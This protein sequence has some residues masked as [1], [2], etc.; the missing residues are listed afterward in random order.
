VE[1]KGEIP[2][3]IKIE[4][5]RIED[6]SL[7]FEDW[8]VKGVPA[9]IRL[10]GI[11]LNIR[12]LRFPVVSGHSPIELKGK[13]KGE[14]R[15]G[16]I[17]ANGWIDL[18]TMDLSTSLK[19]LSVELKTFEPYYKKKVSAEIESGYMNM[20]LN[21]TIKGKKIDAPGQIE[22]LDLKIKEDGTIFYIPAKILISLLSRRE[23]RIKFKFHVNGDMGDPRFKLEENIFARIGA[24]LAESMGIPIKVFGEKFLEG[25]EKG[26]EGLIEGL[27][28][29]EELFKKKRKK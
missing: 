27:R 15:D 14:K 13:I 12:Q 29:I 5:F 16:E 4:R 2:I 20:D 9:K 10:S 23:N 11:D 22:L 19:I 3:Y 24:S 18:K 6:G 21:I 28:S 7:N 17:Y 25:S 8:G 26:A 1:S